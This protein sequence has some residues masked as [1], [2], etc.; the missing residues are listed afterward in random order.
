MPGAGEG[1]N[2]EQLLHR[3]PFGVMKLFLNKIQIGV[4]LTW[5]YQMPLNCSLEDSFILYEFHL[6]CFKKHFL[7]RTFDI[8]LLENCPYKVTLKQQDTF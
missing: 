4:T 5:M 7:L 6:N 2:G 8:H 1:R 3:F